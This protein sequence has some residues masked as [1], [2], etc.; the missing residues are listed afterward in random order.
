MTPCNVYRSGKKAETYLY[1]SDGMEFAELPEEL[2]QRIAAVAR[3]TSPGAR[4]LIADFCVPDHG[5][6]RLRARLILGGLY[7]CF[8]IATRLPARRTC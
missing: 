6:Q 2:Q 1:L 8:R 3:C 5:W 4:W 7:A